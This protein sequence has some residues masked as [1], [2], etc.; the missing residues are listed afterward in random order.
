VYAIYRSHAL[1]QSLGACG[2]RG[3]REHYSIQRSADRLLE[4][5]RTVIA[6]RG[7]PDQVRPTDVGRAVPGPA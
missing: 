2:F 4:V 1:A 3:V 7:E 5:Y 6:G